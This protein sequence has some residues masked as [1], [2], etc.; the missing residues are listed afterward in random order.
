MVAGTRVLVVEDEAMVSMMLEDFLEDLGCVVVATASRLEE[1]LKKAAELQI[2]VAVL[3]VNLAGKLSYPVAELLRSL[4][5]ESELRCGVLF[6]VSEVE[7]A[8]FAD[9]ICTLTPKGG[10]E[11]MSGH[12][13]QPGQIIPFPQQKD[14]LGA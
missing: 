14:A 13:D 12:T 4:V 10:L 2:D 9:R 3:D 5:E 8:L 1:A 11:V 6:S 7:S